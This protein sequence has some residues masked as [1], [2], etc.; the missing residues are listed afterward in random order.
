M[1]TAKTPDVEKEKQAANEPEVKDERKEKEEEEDE[2]KRKEKNADKGKKKGEGKGEGGEEEENSNNVS[3]NNTNEGVV[4]SG[5]KDKKGIKSEG[6]SKNKK[7]FQILKNYIYTHRD[8]IFFAVSHFIISIFMFQMTKR[9][10]KIFSV[11][12]FAGTVILHYTIFAVLSLVLSSILISSFIPNPM[13]FLGISIL[14]HI[15][16]FVITYYVF[17]THIFWTME[18]FA[19]VRDQSKFASDED[20]EFDVPENDEFDEN[21]NENENENE[22]EK[23]PLSLEEKKKQHGIIITAS[24]MH[25]MNGALV[26]SFYL[27]F[28]ISM[29]DMFLAEKSSLE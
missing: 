22:K 15:S 10:P 12:T 21:E 6:G 5:T 2:G 29:R 7:G 17:I 19:E 20:D 28:S 4:N 18:V 9:Y 8:V 26:I 25:I 13:F 1:S 3:I 24:R 27:L 11:D 16:M 23:E 14:S